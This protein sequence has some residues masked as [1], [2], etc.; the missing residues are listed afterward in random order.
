M[1]IQQVLTK[2][3]PA[4]ILTLLGITFVRQS[5][6]VHHNFEADIEHSLFLQIK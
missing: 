1:T 4:L 5:M 3:D 2:C 6:D